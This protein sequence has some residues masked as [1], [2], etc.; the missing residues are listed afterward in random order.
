[1]N[2]FG[3]ELEFNHN[4]IR[5]KIEDCCLQH[6]KGYVCIV[7]GPSLVRSHTN[8]DFLHVLK[9]AYFNSCDGGSV[10]SMAGHL[11]KQDLRAFTGPEILGEYIS[12]TDLRQV[13][14]GNTAEVY[15]K[16]IDKIPD[17]SSHLFHIPLPFCSVR[18]FNY[19]SIAQEIDRLNADIIW[20]SLGAPKQE[21]FMQLLLPHLKRGIM[22]G[23]G[24]A[25]AF[26][27]G[28]LKDY[29]FRIGENRLNWIYRLFREP[30]KQ[31][32][33]VS[34]IFRYY[35]TIYIKEKKRIRG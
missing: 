20:V 11:Y 18:E 10:A 8:P 27:L 12:R 34:T 13:M 1:M 4:I 15:Q 5:Q 23:I 22:L 21:F 17:A 24:A 30:R 35:P 14:L 19:E 16:V 31:F 28:E 33:R 2:I 29:Q 6:G 25:F 3:F 7:D 32:A 9:G 26:Y